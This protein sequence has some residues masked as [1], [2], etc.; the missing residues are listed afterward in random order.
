RRVGAGMGGMRGVME[1]GAENLFRVW[2]H[3]QPF[4]VGLLVV[5]LGRVG[6]LAYFG[7]PAS[8]E[9][10]TQARVTQTL[11]QGDHAIASHYAE[12]RLSIGH[13][14]RELHSQLHAVRARWPAESPCT[15]TSAR[16][17]CP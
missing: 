5:G 10:I 16:R 14:A 15:L 8:R 12:A 3:R 4:D 6:G 17:Y 9:R 13:I 11:V 1:A 2:D 7:K